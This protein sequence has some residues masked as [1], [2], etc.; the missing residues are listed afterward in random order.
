MEGS[1]PVDRLDRR[2]LD[3]AARA[4]LRAEGRVEPNPMVGCVIGTR[5]GRV[6]ATGHHRRFGG[7][8]AEVDALRACAANGHSPEGKIAW[9]T[10]EP[11][12][13]TGKTPACSRALIEAGIGEVVVARRD[14]NELSAGGIE[15]LRGA[16]VA[17]RLTG[18][19]RLAC[20]IGDPFVKRI[21]T[22][23]P[24]IIAKWAQSIDGRVA[25]SDGES[26][27]ITGEVTRRHV[28]RVRGRVDAIITGAG[29]VL[30]D[31]PLLT[32]RGVPVRRCPRRVVVDPQLRTPPDSS[33]V[34][35][36]SEGQVIVAHVE[37]AN[38]AHAE[39]LRRAGVEVIAEPEAGAE[40]LDLGALLRRLHREFG[41]A[42][43]LVE[44]GP[45]LM[46]SL[47]DA[48]LIDEVHVYQGPIVMG[49]ARA[50]PPIAG[51]ARESLPSAPRYELFARR[52]FG[53]DTLTIYRRPFDER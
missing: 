16:G 48:G 44:S 29:T 20:R 42:T 25:L 13:H 43:A 33:L 34:R 37:G 21:L 36:V 32:P 9:V 24:W 11:C 31:D 45:G 41:I 4:A 6:L 19:S 46:G 38:P 3:R 47:L 14:P 40:H 53:D 39:A 28:H 49:D 10:L 8:H 35:S 5:D 17:T 50:L 1:A 2:M 22:G 18:A 51:A 52:R 7:E 30:A 12:S 27:W 15:S 23:L 26:R